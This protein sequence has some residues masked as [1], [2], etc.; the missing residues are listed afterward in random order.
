M[1][2]ADTN[3]IHQKPVN[4]RFGDNAELLEQRIKDVNW[5]YF[6]KVYAIGFGVLCASLFIIIVT[7]KFALWLF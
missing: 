6:G 3:K 1:R 2:F 5:Q 7:V 4:E